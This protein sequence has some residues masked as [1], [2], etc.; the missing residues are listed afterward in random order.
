MEHESD[1]DT[2]CNQCTRYSH[3]RICKGARRI[4]N[5][6]ASGDHSNDSTIKIG[7]NNEKSP[8]DMRWIAVIQTPVKDYQLMLVW[9]TLEGVE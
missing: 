1:G 6:K 3:Q 9:K 4:G 8:G 7:Q 2:N 5:K